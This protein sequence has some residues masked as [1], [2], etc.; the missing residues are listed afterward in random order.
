MKHDHFYQW[1][2]VED[3]REY[4]KD[5]LKNEA[6]VT[7]KS[8]VK[9][10]EM[11]GASFIAD[12]ESIFGPL[13]ED[14]I[15]REIDWY[16]SQSLYVDDIEGKV[17]AI[18]EMVS[19]RH[20]RI[21]SNY[22]WCVFSEE[23]G[24]QF[25]NAL[26]ALA[27]DQNT[28]QAIMIYNRPTMHVDSKADGMADFMC[29]NAVQFVIR[30]NTL[31]AIVQMRSNDVVFGYR[32]DRAWQDYVLRQLHHALSVRYYPDLQLGDIH[33]SVGSLHVYSRHFSLIDPGYTERKK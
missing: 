19:S 22:G 14:Y 17:P 4:F 1:N 30:D 6:Y 9:T 7:D 33:W 8:G 11:I 16:L 12:E 29:T 20:S 10:V 23:N 24:A 32:N 28:R 31:H 13:N 5:L 21:N 18:W 3:I 2:K 15:R 26:R 27:A 25:S